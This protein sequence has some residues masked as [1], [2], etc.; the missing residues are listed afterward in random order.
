M[1]LSVYYVLWD[2]REAAIREDGSVKRFDPCT[3][4][5]DW[6]GRVQRVLVVA[7][8]SDPLVGME[9]LSDREP[10]TGAVTDGGVTIPQD[11]KSRFRGG[12]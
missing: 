10:T 6:D 1:R 4:A 9:L 2:G 12:L 3:A 11:M 5:I 7:A 8:G